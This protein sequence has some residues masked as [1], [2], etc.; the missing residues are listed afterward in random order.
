MGDCCEWD[1]SGWT[2]CCRGDNGNK[3]LRLRGNN[4]GQDVEQIEKPCENDITNPGA[5]YASCSVIRQTGISQVRQG[6][7]LTM[8]QFG[9]TGKMEI[10][11]DA[12]AVINPDK[13]QNVVFQ[14]FK[15]VEDPMTHKVISNAQIVSANVVMTPQVVA[16]QAAP[17]VVNQTFQPAQPAQ[18]PI[19]QPMSQQQPQ[20]V[21]SQTDPAATIVHQQVA[22][23]PKKEETTPNNPF[24]PFN[25]LFS[26]N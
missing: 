20:M 13:V 22:V 25:F 5:T 7:S 9:A 2:G 19:F 14:D 15:R 23:E 21:S 3:R 10:A 11:Q 17:V 24:S 1:W 4:C 6:A 8:F 18:V 12:M 16:G 26:G